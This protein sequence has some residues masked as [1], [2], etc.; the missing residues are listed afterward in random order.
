MILYAIGDEHA[1]AAKAVNGCVYAEDDKNFEVIGKL[2]HPDNSHISWANKVAY[3]LRMTVSIGEPSKSNTVIVERITNWIASISDQ[4]SPD[5]V[6]IIVGWN[7]PEE[8]ESTTLIRN[9][10]IYLDQ[11]GIKHAFFWTKEKHEIDYDFRGIFL[12]EVYVD[13][14]K[15]NGHDHV[16]MSDEYFGNDAHTEWAKYLLLHIAQNAIF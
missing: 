3:A 4:L 16:I 13:Y 15:N 8:N 10:H 5:E 12:T 1:I 9:F 6:V 11:L 2:A 7:A 14:V